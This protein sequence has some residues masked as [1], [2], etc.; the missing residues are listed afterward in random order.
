MSYK[1]FMESIPREKLEKLLTKGVYQLEQHLKPTIDEQTI[2]FWHLQLQF[3]YMD[4]YYLADI[5]SMIFHNKMLFTPLHR[6]HED[7]ATE[8][9]LHLSGLA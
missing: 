3:M 1:E 9:A 7:I 8:L 6:K 2:H 4:E 5:H